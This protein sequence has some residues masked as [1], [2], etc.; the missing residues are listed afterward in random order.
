LP[1]HAPIHTTFLP[2]HLHGRRI[3]AYYYFNLP[4]EQTI[5]H[6]MGQPQESRVVWLHNEQAIMSP[7]WSIHAAAGTY[8]YTFIWGMGGE[9]QDY[10]DQDFYKITD[11]K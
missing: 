2:P 6:I 5:A 8:Y 4:A 7:E 9:N 11:L 1:V 10:G 3:E